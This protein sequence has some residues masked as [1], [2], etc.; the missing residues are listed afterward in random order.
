MFQLKVLQNGYAILQW[1]WQTFNHFLKKLTTQYSI[2]ICRHHL[3]SR[4]TSLLILVHGLGSIFSIV[5]GIHISDWI[6]INKKSILIY[7]FVE[8]FLFQQI[9][10]LYRYT[11]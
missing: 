5:M 9:L 11:P 3:I 7:K 6:A 8:T 2:H 1:S 4:E 10:R